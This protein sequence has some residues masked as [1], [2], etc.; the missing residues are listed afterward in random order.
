[1]K[2]RAEGDDTLI[3]RAIKVEFVDIPRVYHYMD[4]LTDDFFSALASTEQ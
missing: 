4:D 1:M 3:D 2:Q